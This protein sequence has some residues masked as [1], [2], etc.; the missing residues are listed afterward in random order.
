MLFFHQ[1]WIIFQFFGENEVMSRP[2]GLWEYLGGHRGTLNEMEDSCAVWAC[3]CPD[4]TNTP[5]ASNRQL[6]K[7]SKKVSLKILLLRLLINWEKFLGKGEIFTQGTV[8]KKNN[9]RFIVRDFIFIKGNLKCDIYSGR[10]I[11]RDV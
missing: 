10:F 5:L 1:S 2:N 3:L 7:S 9:G 6:C 4:S 11:V 8:L